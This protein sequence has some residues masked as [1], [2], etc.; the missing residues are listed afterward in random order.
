MLQPTVAPDGVAAG[1]SYVVE[2]DENLWKQLDDEQ[3]QFCKDTWIKKA[4]PIP[5]VSVVCLRLMPDTLFPMHG[6]EH[7][8]IEWQH[9]IEQ[10]EDRPP[11]KYHTVL[12]RCNEDWTPRLQSAIMRDAASRLP[13]GTAFEIQTKGG[14]PL[15]SGKL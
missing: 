8:Y 3:R 10:K 5:G 1:M 4:T 11:F 15:S 13:S 7:P 6:H 9:T 12:I 2:Y 14:Q